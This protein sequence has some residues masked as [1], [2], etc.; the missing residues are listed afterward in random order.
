MYFHNSG[1]Y[2]VGQNNVNTCETSNIS[3]LRCVLPPFAFNTISNLLIRDSYNC[4]IVFSWMLSIK[5]L[6]V[7]LEMLEE[8]IGFS[9]FFCKKVYSGS[10]HV[11]CLA[12]R[13]GFMIVT[14]SFS[15][16]GISFSD[17]NVSQFAVLS[18]V[19]GFVKF[20]VVSFLW[21]LDLPGKWGFAVTFAVVLLCWRNP[22]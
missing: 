18:W 20:F 15:L 1:I 8:G 13:P 9:L 11:I 12:K 7:V 17:S 4:W 2:R 3:L 16:L 6:P 22:P 19:I 5:H 21:E 10:S 14:P